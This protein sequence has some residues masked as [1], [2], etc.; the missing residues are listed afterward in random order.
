ML[1]G[2]YSNS[3]F[4]FYRSLECEST[5]DTTTS[6]TQELQEDTNEP[7]SKKLKIDEWSSFSLWSQHTFH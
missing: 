3:S 4:N 2:S 5:E 1:D 6:P 7:E